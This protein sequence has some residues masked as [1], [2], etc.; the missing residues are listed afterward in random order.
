MAG[1]V[2]TVALRALRS[3]GAGSLGALGEGEPA[4]VAAIVPAGEDAQLA[5]AAQGW[6]ASWRRRCRDSR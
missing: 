6:S 4:E 1:R 5:R 3:V 2:L